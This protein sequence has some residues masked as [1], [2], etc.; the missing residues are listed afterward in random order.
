MLMKYLP[1]SRL[2]LRALPTALLGIN[3]SLS[4]LSHAEQ[5]AEQHQQ[6]ATQISPVIIVGTRHPRTITDVASTVSLITE[7]DIQQRQIINLTDLVREEPGVSVDGGD[8]RF[9]AGGFRIRGIG[10]NRV[11]TLIDQIPI[12]DRFFVGSYADSGRDYLDTGMISRVEILRGPAS[13][14][15]GSQA[16]GG[17]VSMQTLSP[18][19]LLRHDNNDD[20]NRSAQRLLTGYRGDRDGRFIAG[21]SAWGSDHNDFLIALGA[22]QQNER[23]PADLADSSKLDRS[24]R[25]H[26]SALIKQQSQFGNSSTVTMTLDVDEVRKDTDIRAIL[27]TG[28]FANTTEMLTDDSQSRWRASLHHEWLPGNFTRMAW[29]AY[30]QQ[31]EVEQNTLE[32]R[33]LATPPLLLQRRFSYQQNVHGIGMD[34]QHDRILFG[35]DHLIGSGL[36][37]QAGKLTQQRDALQINLDD[38]SQTNVVLGETF[39][40]RDFPITRTI[41]AGLYLNDEIRLPGSALIVIPGV[42]YDFQQLRSERDLVLDNGSADVA[43]TNQDH[44]RLTGN[45][46]LRWPVNDSWSVYAQYAQGFRA[47]PANDVNLA[48][49]I[50]TPA[51]TAISLP[52]PDLKP[53]TSDSYEVGIR[54]EQP[55]RGFSLALFDN[56]YDDFIQS[57]TLVAVD[58]STTPVTRT[59]QSINIDEARIYGAELRYR[60]AL[61]S[62]PQW[63]IELGAEWLRGIDRS[64]DRPLTDVGPP[65]AVIVFVWEPF[66]AAWAVRSINTLVRHHDRID[67]TVTTPYEP[68]GYSVHDLTADYRFARNWTVRGGIFNL[69]DKHYFDWSAIAG[70][71]ATD[72]LL[73]Y[74]AGSGRH[75]S[76]TLQGRF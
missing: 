6:N 47:P 26:H 16:L 13:V 24:D 33:A 9:G 68:A 31:S 1:I 17:V 62:L 35:T 40:L 14:L 37:L 44:D 11:L 46:G 12:A 74:L 27:G 21:Q 8:S 50:D 30:S 76:I 23:E 48:L 5:Y 61:L 43:L 64:T 63:S 73:P 3:A 52:N 15:H 67:D 42:R 51:G 38:D 66:G 69:T 18:D 20:S 4:G 41:N 36:D 22:R 25:N 60:Q 56:H 59:F 45:F 10:G 19:D 75:A 32:T 28:R 72:P 2:F 70:R 54:M 71:T 57:R 29:R 55:E 49:N 34:M 53:E 7:E 39:P 65:K 58:N